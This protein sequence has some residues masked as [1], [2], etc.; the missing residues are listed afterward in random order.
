M[1]TRIGT[2]ISVIIF[3][4]ILIN[5]TDKFDKNSL[6]Y[7]LIE[8]NNINNKLDK[9]IL[10]VRSGLLRHYNNID[11]GFLDIVKSYSKLENRFI[12]SN[13]ISSDYSE[14]EIIKKTINTSLEKLKNIIN[15]KEDLANTLKSD[16]G[17]LRNS[18][19]YF[20]V[21]NEELTLKYKNQYPDSVKGSHIKS[22][23]NTN[24]INEYNHVKDIIN[25][26][27]AFINSYT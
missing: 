6:Q 5:I 1:L 18:L 8:L 2:I 21:L 23:K 19:M 4:F 9:D 15:I 20:S 16:I 17:V 7:N 13:S 22:E 10:L 11:R 26:D 27:L 14:I 25:I 12:G 3:M 24:N